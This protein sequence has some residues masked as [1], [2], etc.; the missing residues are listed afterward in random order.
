MAAALLVL[1][2]LFCGLKF[3]GVKRFGDT[4]VFAEI[5][6]LSKRYFLTQ[7]SNT[8]GYWLPPIVISYVYSA[9]VSADY[10][11]A[12]R[13]GFLQVFVSAAIGFPI[14]RKVASLLK[15][16][17][18]ELIALCRKWS[19]FSLIF[20]IAI[21]TLSYFAEHLLNGISSVN[22]DYSLVRVFLIMSTF[23]SVFYIYLSVFTVVSDTAQ[24]VKLLLISFLL[25]LAISVVGYYF[26]KLEILAVG[27]SIILVYPYVHAYLFRKK[28]ILKLKKNL[29]MG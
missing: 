6:N 9:G 22:L 24:V 15:N 27:L 28:V 17:A 20:A 11:F 5:N 12:F 2:L 14:L 29:E 1:W 13:L 3:L 16:D 8:L 26:A 4:G 19:V 23:V 7:L 18:D 10:N 21:L 25:S